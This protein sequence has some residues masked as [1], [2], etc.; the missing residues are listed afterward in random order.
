M[1]TRAVEGRM[2]EDADV[3]AMYHQ[4]WTSEEYAEGVAAFLAKRPPDFHAA[5]RP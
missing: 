3:V 5:R 1:I 2:D 4:S